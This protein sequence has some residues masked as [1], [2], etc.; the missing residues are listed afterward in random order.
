MSPSNPDS[1]PVHEGLHELG[2]Q[3]EESKGPVAGPEAPTPAEPAAVEPVASAEPP[4]LDDETGAVRG[5]SGGAASAGGAGTGAP[6]PD[7]DISA[8]AAQPA[9]PADNPV[10]RGLHELGLQIDQAKQGGGRGGG[11]GGR[12]GRRGARSDAGG[13]AHAAP[14][15][16]RS[17]R[18]KVG[19]VVGSLFLVLVL[20]AGAAAGYG[21]YLN[22]EIHR[23]D[24]HNLTSSP[25]KGADAGT[26]NILMI[27]STS[28]CALKVQNPAYGLC[29]QGVTGVNSDV[30]MILHLNPANNTLSIL[31]IPRDL[32]VP[33]AR[34]D[35]ANKIDA[36]LYQGPDQLIN[37]IEEDY[38]IP[39]QHFVELNFD[40]FINVVQALGGIKM[41][42]PEPV[43]DS[44]SGLNIQTTGCISLNGTQALQVVRARHLQYKPPGVTTTNPNYWPQESQSDLARIRR[45]H[46]FLRVLA[47][48]VKAK[49]LSNPITD[50]G[51]VS[52][53]VGDL[54]VDSNF[55]ATDMISLVLNYHGVNVNKSPQL[56][57]PVQV[58]QF[59]NYVYQ[60][61]SYG[62]IEFPSEPQDHAAVDQFLGLKANAD[63]Y[64]G[65]ALP[66]PS[67]VTVSVM[68]GSGAYNQATD[69][70]Q[71]L[72]ALGFTIGTIGDT[73]PV[74]R[75]AETVV[76]YSSK[77]PKELAAAQAVADSMTGGVIMADDAS[78]VKPGSQVTVV[79]GTDFTVNSSPAPPV[80][81]GTGS[82]A[83]G[84]STTATRSTGSSGNTGNSGS[85]SSSNGAFQPPTATVSPLA[86]WD[87]RSCTPSGGEG[88]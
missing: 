30:V 29:S 47:S 34:S 3:I 15:K 49:G 79:T 25:G 10:E 80:S 20:I 73:T 9:D 5:A 28:R 63:T 4:A 64:S 2:R 67:S 74:G 85:S 57:L 31:S 52:G 54:T 43:Y 7:P 44:Y 68:N 13:P 71:S 27:G 82:A 22:H 72:K 26:E 55:S 75:E 58:D 18:R 70:A 11:G 50:Q 48:A 40:S 17:T 76:Y 59:G 81:A 38:G 88:T 14:K 12:G 46:E 42:F 39:I 33:N 62:D 61:G 84:T 78:Q 86:P 23:I 41:Y 53:V 1:D 36:A 51:L 35:G 8:L 66:A 69:T 77:S 6:G 24:L 21:W 37:A 87:P 19:Y 83:G 65:G 45:D 60:G 56:T 16:K 32:F